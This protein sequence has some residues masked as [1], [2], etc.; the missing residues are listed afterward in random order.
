M[1]EGGLACAVAESALWGGIGVTL[2]LEPLMRRADVDAQTAFFGEGPAGIVVSGP[3]E[4]LMELSND[5]SS[6]GFLALGTTGGDDIQLTAGAATI[7]LP[8]EE[9]RS[10]F[11]SAL[12]F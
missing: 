9:A 11:G 8:V 12:R 3:R 4:A 1:S 6:V 5:A 10:V 2:D 7:A